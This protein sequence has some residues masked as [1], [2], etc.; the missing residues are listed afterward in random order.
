MYTTAHSVRSQT[1]PC[2]TFLQGCGLKP[3]LRPERYHHVQ[4]V[5]HQSS[6][7]QVGCLSRRSAVGSDFQHRDDDPCRHSQRRPTFGVHL[8][9][10]PPFHQCPTV[11]QRHLSNCQWSEQLSAS[12]SKGREVAPMESY[13]GKSH[14]MPQ[15][16]H[17]GIY[18]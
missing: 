17:P 15:P 13:E 14:K 6:S 2:S 5:V 9:S 1:L 18:W 10:K 4:I 11:C 16:R 3:I 12:P 8:R 7:I